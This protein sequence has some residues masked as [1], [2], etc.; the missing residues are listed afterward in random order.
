MAVLGTALLLGACASAESDGADSGVSSADASSQSAADAQVPDAAPPL[1]LTVLSPNG[2][3]L[4]R[5]NAVSQITWTSPDGMVGNVSIELWKAGAKQ[6][7]IALDEPDDGVFD[8]TV[9]NTVANAADYRVRIVALAD[10]AVND[11]SDA[12]F[13]IDDRSLT[14]TAPNGAESFTAGTSTTV[15]WTSVGVINNVDITLHKAG[16]YLQD[17]ALGV[18]NNGSFTWDLATNLIDAD[19]YSVVVTDAAGPVFDTSDAAFSVANWQYRIPITITSPSSRTNFPV[20][21]DLSAANFIFG[22]AEADGSDVRFATNVNRSAGFDLDHYTE[23]WSPPGSARIW[24][25]VPS[26]PAGS[27]VT[28]YMFYGLSGQSSTSDFNSTFPSRFTSAGTHTLNGT[29]SVDAYTL[30]AG[31][32]VNIQT[33]V[34]GVINARFVRINGTINGAGRGYAGGSGG[35]A[36]SGTG[37]GGGGGGATTRGGGGGGHGGT[38]GTGGRDSGD[39]VAAG[40][41]ANGS[42]STQSIT[43]G[44]GGGSADS[45][46]GGRGGGAITINGGSVH[47]TGLINVSGAVGIGGTGR[48]GGGGAGGGIMIVTSD[49]TLSGTLNAS[50][51]NGGSGT[52]AINDDGGGGAGGRIKLFSANTAVDTSSKTVTGGQPGPFGGIPGGVGGTGSTASVPVTSQEPATVFGIQELAF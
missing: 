42:S 19:D 12:D 6:F 23:S 38:G 51:G 44:S 29:I 22:N 34:P 35:G 41:S 36:G 11:E 15:S 14:V 10:S 45:A 16:A 3:E 17:I 50:G 1:T 9:P 39:P 49:A 13:A 30:S 28:I 27:A 7:D 46:A 48:N 20:I 31:H 47:V 4:L 2:G 40:G 32:T 52:E 25:N 8:W 37:G 26:L 33:G 43:M 24:V 5:T 21:I 18:A